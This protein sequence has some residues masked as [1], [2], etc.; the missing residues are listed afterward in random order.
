ML[1]HCSAGVGRTGAFILLDSMLERI[2]SESTVNVYA[3]LTHMR[4]QRVH[5]VQTLV[6]CSPQ[7]VLSSCMQ[8]EILSSDVLIPLFTTVDLVH[9]VHVDPVDLVD[10]CRPHVHVH[11]YT[12]WLHVAMCEAGLTLQCVSIE[13][14]FCCEL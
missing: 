1:V 2:M 12:C 4:T 8:L 7:P 5:L 3:F 13:W 10:H 11:V 9:R 14:L 6:R